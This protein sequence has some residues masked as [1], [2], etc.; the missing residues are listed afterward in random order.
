MR[1]R[2]HGRCR[3]SL[4]TASCF[5]YRSCAAADSGTDQCALLALDDA[6]DAGARR[7]RAADDHRRLRPRP[8]VTW[9]DLFGHS[10]V[11]AHHGLPDHLALPNWLWAGRAIHGRRTGRAIDRSGRGRTGRYEPHGFGRGSHGR[12]GTSPARLVR[13]RRPP[14]AQIPVSEMHRPVEPRPRC[15]SRP[16]KSATLPSLRLRQPASPSRHPPDSEFDDSA[17]LGVIVPRSV[18]SSSVGL[19]GFR[20]MVL[21]Q[22]LLPEARAETVHCHE[23]WT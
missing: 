21:A 3:I 16:L 1:P 8:F 13:T 10:A 6:S 4:S 15:T 5:V 12:W 14:S 9:R 19:S 23:L 7:R 22:S 2:L 20:H 18:P 11:F 17:F